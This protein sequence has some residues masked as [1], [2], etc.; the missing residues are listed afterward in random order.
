MFEKMAQ[1]GRPISFPL[2]DIKRYGN[3]PVYFQQLLTSFEPVMPNTLVQD[4]V[5]NISSISVI[6]FPH[7]LLE[8]TTDR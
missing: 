4:A 1:C 5:Q 6:D 7:L 3:D 2:Q 8:F